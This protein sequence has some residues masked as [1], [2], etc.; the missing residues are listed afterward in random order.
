MMR[1]GGGCKKETSFLKVEGMPGDAVGLAF[2][3]FFDTLRNDTRFG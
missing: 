2:W 1:E 3:C